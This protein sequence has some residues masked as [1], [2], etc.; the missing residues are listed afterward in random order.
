MK[1]VRQALFIAGLLGVA[2][3]TWLILTRFKPAATWLQLEAPAHIATDRP[4]G[5]RITLADPRDHLHLAVDLHGWKQNEERVGVVARALPQRVT[6]ASRSAMS[7]DFTVP[8]LPEVNAVSA[9]IYLSPTGQWPDRIRGVAS[10]KIPVRPATQAETQELGTVATYEITPDPHVPRVESLLLRCLIAGLWLVVAIG[11]ILRLQHARTH[12]DG[13]PR[14]SLS[15]DLALAGACLAPVFVEMLGSE[16]ALGDLARTVA[17]ELGLYG[18]RH[19]PQ[20]VAVI[21]VA[22]GAAAIGGVALLRTR[23]RRVVLGLL[24]YAALSFTAALSLH[25]TDVLLYSLI[26]GQAVEQLAK[27]L[28]VSLAIWGLRPP[29]TAARIA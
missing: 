5:I 7:F 22:V 11:M 23:H 26:F 2:G 20:Q 18:E 10:D 14:R 29:G 19:L 15:G 21:F 9:V 6:T 16:Q 24:I 27:L 28:A 4:T 8:A 13:L 25:E 3:L 12:S 1:P 17:L